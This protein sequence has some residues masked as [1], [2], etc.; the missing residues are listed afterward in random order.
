MTIT[1]A[2][3]TEAKLRAKAERE[4]QDVNTVTG[5]LLTAALE[6]EE[7]GRKAETEA[8]RRGLE[9]CAAGRT[10]P[11]AEFAAEMR[12]KYNL[13]THLTDEELTAPS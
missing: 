6:W 3:E 8:I 11:L 1:I 13:P 12:T 4:G 9:A 2:P 5:A 10:R 7:R